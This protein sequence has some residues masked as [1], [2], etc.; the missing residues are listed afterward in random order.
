MGDFVEFFLTILLSLL[1]QNNTNNSQSKN[2]P[3]ISP[4]SLSS[5]P[6]ALDN[7]PNNNNRSNNN[8]NPI[9]MDYNQELLEGMIKKYF[10][11]YRPTIVLRRC[12]DWGNWNAAALVSFYSIALYN[13]S[14]FLNPTFSHPYYLPLFLYPSTNIGMRTIRRVIRLFGL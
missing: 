5:S 13:L 1:R 10:K 6:S 11:M 14:S 12:L 8:N 3:I 2:N 4:P 7:N 9:P